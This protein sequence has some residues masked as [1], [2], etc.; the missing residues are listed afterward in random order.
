MAKNARIIGTGHSYPEGIL[1]NADLEGMV[2]V[3]L[4]LVDVASN[5]DA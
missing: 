3:T 1:T 2:E 5:A 4:A